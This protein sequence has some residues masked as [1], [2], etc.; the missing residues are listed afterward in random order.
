MIVI[1]IHCSTNENLLV[2]NSLQQACRMFVEGLSQACSRLATKNTQLLTKFYN[3]S[4]IFPFIIQGIAS[5][6]YLFQY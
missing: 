4:I 3:G 6:K 5:D 2:Q 1:N